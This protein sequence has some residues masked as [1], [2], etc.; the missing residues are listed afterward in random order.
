MRYALWL[1]MLCKSGLG[2]G[3]L[4]TQDHTVKDKI[5]QHGEKEGSHQSTP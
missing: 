4:K 1:L 3:Q 5:T 2:A